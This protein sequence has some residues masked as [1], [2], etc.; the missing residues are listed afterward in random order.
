M[1]LLYL[2]ERGFWVYTFQMGLNEHL[3]NDLLFATTT[4][5]QWWMQPGSLGQVSLCACSVLVHKPG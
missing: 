3:M 2:I 4:S 5:C 1:T